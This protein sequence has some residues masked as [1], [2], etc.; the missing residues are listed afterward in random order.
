MAQS[1]LLLRGNGLTPVAGSNP[2]LSVL[3]AWCNWITFQSTKLKS[4]GS[5]PSAIVKFFPLY[6]PVAQLVVSAYLKNRRSSVRFRPGGLSL[7]CSLVVEQ[8]PVKRMVVGSIP[9]RAAIY[10]IAGW[11]IRQVAVALNDREVGSTPTPVSNHCPV[12]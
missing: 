9:T 6:P 10:F 1:V 5:I 2:V 3:I 12:V 8:S 7:P 4:E 11:T